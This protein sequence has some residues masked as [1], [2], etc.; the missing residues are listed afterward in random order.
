MSP[1]SVAEGSDLCMN[2]ITDSVFTQ[3]IRGEVDVE[4]LFLFCNR[5]YQTAA[6]LTFSPSMNWTAAV[7]Q[8]NQ[9]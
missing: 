4:N 5:K 2:E 9:S 3:H 7:L 1:V 8:W 6:C